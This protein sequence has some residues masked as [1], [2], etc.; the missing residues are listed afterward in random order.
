MTFEDKI[1]SPHD[2]SRNV[3]SSPIADQLRKN[4]P[5]EGSHSGSRSRE[6]SP[7]FI[8][9]SPKMSPNISPSKKKYVT[10][11]IIGSDEKILNFVNDNENLDAVLIKKKSSQN[12][13]EAKKPSIFA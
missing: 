5:K 2:S 7:S 8:K 10:D 13:E 3:I 4:F 12:N 11:T 9:T 1:S 6:K